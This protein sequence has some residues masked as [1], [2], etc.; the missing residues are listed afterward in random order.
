MECGLSQEVP[1]SSNAGLRSEAVPLHL[2]AELY[3]REFRVKDATFLADKRPRL[4]YPVQPEETA[5]LPGW[6]IRRRKSPNHLSFSFATYHRPL[7]SNCSIFR[8][9]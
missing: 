6:I 4:R 3:V 5:G 2:I 7:S 9:T 8:E 1:C